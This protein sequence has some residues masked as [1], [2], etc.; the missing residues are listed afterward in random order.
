MQEKTER[1]SGSEWGEPRHGGGEKTARR[2]RG[3]V[4]N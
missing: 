3:L 4:L 1:R 2:G